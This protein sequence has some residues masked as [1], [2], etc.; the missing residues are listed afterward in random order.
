MLDDSTPQE[1][2]LG[3]II[4]C[5]D[6]LIQAGLDMEQPNKSG[7]PPRL[8]LSAPNELTKWWYDKLVKQSQ[9]AKTDLAAAAQAISVTA[10]LVATASYVGP[11]QPPLGL[12]TNAEA[13]LTGYSQVNH[14]AVQVFLFCNSLSFYLA[15]ALIMLSIIPSLTIPQEPLPFEVHVANMV[16]QW[17]IIFLFASIT[18]VICSFSAAS[19]AVV[20][21]SRWGYKVLAI[22]ST[23]VGALIC[24]L[25]LCLFLLRLTRLVK[26][27]AKWAVNWNKAVFPNRQ[28]K[29]KTD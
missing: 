26:P 1:K 28:P 6:L 10:A 29:K 5:I 12:S 23:I 19:I 22:L 15:I 8:G 18:S 11:L 17:A 27:K 16:I 25:A 4:G 24:S 2:S 21:E 9:E 7:E 14:T 3:G 20:P 13:W